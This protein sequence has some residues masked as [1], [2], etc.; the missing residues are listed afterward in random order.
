MNNGLQEVISAAINGSGHKAA[1]AAAARQV[2]QLSVVETGRPAAL[3][4]D[5]APSASAETTFRVAQAETS[6]R[7]VPAGE[8]D[9]LEHG[10]LRLAF[11]LSGFHDALTERRQKGEELTEQEELLLELSTK[12]F[13]GLRPFAIERTLG[14]LDAVVNA[15][16]L[17]ANADDPGTG[18]PM[19]AFALTTLRGLAN[20]ARQVLEEEGPDAALSLFGDSAGVVEPLAILRLVFST[21]LDLIEAFE[22]IIPT[23]AVLLSRLAEALDSEVDRI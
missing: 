12:D 11:W 19:E 16:D 21:A 20:H 10:G 9:L 14:R 8:S 18:H 6:A 23:E 7:A 22:R 13:A 4:P 2:P 5:P 3:E 17:F 15:P 1:R